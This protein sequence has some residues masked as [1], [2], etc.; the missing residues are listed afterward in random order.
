[1]ERLRLVIPRDAIAARVREL[2]QAI[3]AD[4]TGKAPVLVG[5][6]KGAFVFL[7]DLAREL[8]LPVV[9]DFVGLSSYGLGQTSQGAVAVTYPLK[10]DITGKD[11][12]VVEDIVDSGVTLRFLRDYLAAKG[13]AS[14][15]VCALL[16]REGAAA[17]QADYLGFAMGKGWLVGYGLDSGEEYRYLRDIYVLE[18]GEG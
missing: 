5:V 4:Y 12:L 10:V 8:E 2:A 13:A 6:L 16:A 11:V 14:V 9:V 7:A 3:R 18:E 17:L 15:R 1:M